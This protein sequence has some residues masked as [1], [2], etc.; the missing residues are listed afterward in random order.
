MKEKILRTPTMKQAL[1]P[2]YAMIIFFGIG[3]MVL[4]LPL[5]IL[6]IASAIV[7]CGLA[8]YL[9]HDWKSIQDKIAEKFSQAMPAIII[10]QIIGFLI[11]AWMIAGT[12]PLMIKMGL[13]MIDPQFLFVSAFVGT[14]ML[15]MFTGTS[16]GSAGTLGVA[17]IGV[18]ASQDISLPITAGAIIS[19]A[20]FGDKMSP[21]SD[22]C[23]ITAVAAKTDIFK[24]IRNMT[25][26]AIP[27]AIICLVVYT[28]LGFN[29][30]VVGDGGLSAEAI[31]LLGEVES[32]FALNSPNSFNNFIMIPAVGFILYNVFKRV[33]DAETMNSIV[34]NVLFGLTGIVA[35]L[36]LYGIVKTDL[37]VVLLLPVLFILHGSMN[38]YPTVVLMIG[39]AIIGAILTLI[40]QPYTILNIFNTMV[41]GFKLKMV[42][43]AD[44]DTFSWAARRLMERGGLYS[45]VGAVIILLCAFTIAAGL[46]V[47]GAMKKL[48]D[49]LISKADT[50]FK[51]IGATM[52]TG[53]GLVAATSNGSAAS[54]ITGDSFGKSFHDN[55]LSP[56]NLSRTLEDSVII[57]EPLMFFTV[58]GIYMSDI[59]GVS[60]A[61]YAPWALFCVTGIFFSLM[62]AWLHDYNL[63]KLR[64]L[65]DEDRQYAIEAANIDEKETTIK[66]DILMKNQPLSNGIS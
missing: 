48:I 19:G 1:L 58:S 49:A 32:V 46:E 57:T 11:G 51:L 59:L 56:V 15:S 53:A 9:G 5:E 21:L 23:N 25:W 36:S 42:V 24:H 35:L 26:T 30:T 38:R 54:L 29:T 28:V 37:N 14:A 12:I 13:T 33:S 39:A 4:H 2:V 8:Y 63:C 50:V 6:M 45:L 47:S 44:A 16:W 10:L 60:V 20:Y 17:L 43:G 40:Y 27:S 7:S 65:D 62:W 52:I 41:S 31:A 66:R 3:N 61:E 64:P 18:A 22:S 34:K 55:D